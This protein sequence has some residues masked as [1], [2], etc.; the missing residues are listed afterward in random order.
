MLGWINTCMYLF[1]IVIKNQGVQD[2]NPAD[3]N[4]AVRCMDGWVFN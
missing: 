3:I 2:M 4:M 1:I